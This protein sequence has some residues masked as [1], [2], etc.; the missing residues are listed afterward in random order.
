MEKIL[1]VDDNRDNLQILSDLLSIEN[2]DLYFAMNGEEALERMQKAKPDILLLDVIMPVLDG[3]STIQRIKE[4]PDLSTTPVIFMTAL[5]DE[6][7]IKKGFDLGGV[8]YI[9]KPF[10]EKEVLRRI[11]THLQLQQ[12]VNNL[13]KKVK[14]Q[15]AAIQ[16]L[17]ESFV[18]AL[19]KANYYND[20]DTGFHI[21]RVS[22]YARILAEGLGLSLDVCNEI[23]KYASLHDIGKV[24]IPDSILKKR[25]KLTT[26][27]FAKMKR[28]SF[29]GFKMID[30]PLI[31][32]TA[33][34][35]VLYHHE[36]Y[37]GEGYPENL[38][39]SAIPIEAR[40][41]AIADIYDALR[42]KRPYK[43]PFPRE[44][45]EDIILKSSGNHLDP[46]I[47][48]IFEKNFDQFDKIYDTFSY[49]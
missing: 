28:H 19:E 8:D 37:N 33:K 14:E 47:V 13:D 49:C 3:Y 1:I 46:A 43:E 26:E 4:N 6:E 23:Y 9:T 17:N 48:R 39:G 36:E 34:N 20:D 24:G 5:S 44:K 38:K 27:E 16:Q 30:Y 22:H 45:A 42:S 11:R 21:K 12:V 25:A 35:I 18:L 40:I 10:F 7:S 32:D 41:M 31:P 15:T 29:I 2:Y